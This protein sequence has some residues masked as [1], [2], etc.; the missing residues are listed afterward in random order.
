MVWW[1]RRDIAA[2]IHGSE[3]FLWGHSVMVLSDRVWWIWVLFMCFR[4]DENASLCLVWRRKRPEEASG[5]RSTRDVVC[6]KRLERVWVMLQV[7]P[8]VW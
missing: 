4:R 7:R 6:R 8:W 5:R 3:R 1:W 2:A